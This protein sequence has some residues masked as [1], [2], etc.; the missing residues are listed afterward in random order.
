MKIDS[1]SISRLSRYYLLNPYVILVGAVWGMPDNIIA[2]VLILAVLKLPKP[3]LTGSFLALSVLIKP[4]PVVMLPVFLRYVGRKSWKF[5]LP[6]VLI[7]GV[8]SIAPLLILRGNMNRLFEV[9]AS[10]TSRLPNAIS[11]SAILNNLAWFPLH[12][13]PQLVA[14]WFVLP[15]PVRF[16]WLEVLAALIVLLFLLPKPTAMIQLVAWLRILAVSYYL[17]FPAVSEQTLLPLVVLSMTDVDRSGRLGL[18]ST[19]WLLSI[20]IS[21]F[22][23]LEVPVWKFVYPVIAISISG[24]MWNLTQASAL[25][26]LH[27]LYVVVLLLEGRFSW[28]IVRQGA[29]RH[30][31][32]R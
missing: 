25:I 28:T 11:P 13:T 10:Q 9:L 23:I 22:I 12:I 29:L 8:G 5:L 18:R 24:Q 2:A 26:V 17:L 16:L 15:L 20:V 1:S 14:D 3:K 7:A 6:L 27:I 4:Y 31:G 19:Y 21:A 32:R 30:V